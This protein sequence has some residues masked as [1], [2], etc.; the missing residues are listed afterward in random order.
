MSQQAMQQALEALRAALSEPD[1]TMQ[2]RPERARRV[3]TAIA[4]LEKELALQQGP[5]CQIRFDGKSVQQ[6]LGEA[7][8]DFQQAT[9]CDT[10]EE[11]LAAG[12]ATRGAVERCH[13]LDELIQSWREKGNAPEQCERRIRA[14]AAVEAAWPVIEANDALHPSTAS[15]APDKRKP[16]ELTSWT[17]ALARVDN[18]GRHCP[19]DKCRD[20][21]NAAG[22]DVPQGQEKDRG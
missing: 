14:R 22:V 1:R 18:H 5:E 12:P 6:W 4:T 17:C 20:C 9:G 3:C 13:L 16:W 15:P 21:P 10:A 7:L 19:E 11:F 2:Q 8:F